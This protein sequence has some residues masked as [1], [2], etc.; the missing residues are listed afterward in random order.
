MDA[1][2]WKSEQAVIDALIDAVHIGDGDRK[3]GELLQTIG[4]RP[5]LRTTQPLALR[6]GPL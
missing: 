2:D 6:P 3:P 1:V 5:S 4:R